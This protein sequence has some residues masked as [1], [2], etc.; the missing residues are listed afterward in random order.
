MIATT[1]LDRRGVA[2]TETDGRAIRSPPPSSSYCPRA[3]EAI[4]HVPKRIA[5][6]LSQ[7]ERQVV[8]SDGGGILQQHTIEFRHDLRAILTEGRD[9]GVRRAEV[10]RREQL[11]ATSS[12]LPPN[13]AMSTDS[14]PDVVVYTGTEGGSGT[15]LIR[16]VRGNGDGRWVGAAGAHRT[17]V[18]EAPDRTS[19]WS[20]RAARRLSMPAKTRKVARAAKRT[21]R[22]VALTARSGPA[23]HT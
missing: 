13:A 15:G 4:E 12:S 20:Q 8:H 11:W 2:A 22:R 1:T 10:P 17:T 23:P 7:L 21:R 3:A 16:P 9:L 18:D 6:F 5:Q 14:T 19:L